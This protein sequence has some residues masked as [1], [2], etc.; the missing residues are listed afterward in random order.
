MTNV[1]TD[2]GSAESYARHLPCTCPS[3]EAGNGFPELGNTVSTECYSVL[4]CTGRSEFKCWLSHFLVGPLRQTHVS[5]LNLCFI[6]KTG[7][8]MLISQGGWEDSGR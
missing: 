5:S 3:P 6:C 7:A 1:R 2:R 4:K 8:Y